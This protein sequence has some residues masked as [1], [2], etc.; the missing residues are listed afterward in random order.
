MGFPRQEYWSELPFPTLGDLSDRGIES[1]SLESSALEGDSL[2]L[3]P[4]G[5]P[6]IFV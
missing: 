6:Q 5:K 2:P 4:P 3:A 1:L